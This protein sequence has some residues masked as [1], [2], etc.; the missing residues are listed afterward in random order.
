MK[1]VNLER[2]FCVVA[3]EPPQSLKCPNVKPDPFIMNDLTPV[4][5]TRGTNQTHIPVRNANSP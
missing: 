5:H 4:I 2:T 3:T 1:S